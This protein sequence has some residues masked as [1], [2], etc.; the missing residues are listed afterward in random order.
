L[1]C[2]SNAYSLQQQ[3]HF[4]GSSSIQLELQ[5]KALQQ[6][7]KQVAHCCKLT[8]AVTLQFFE[9]SQTVDIAASL[10]LLLLSLRHGRYDRCSAN[11]RTRS[12]CNRH[13]HPTAFICTARP[14]F[15]LL[16]LLLTTQGA[17]LLGAAASSSCEG[18]CLQ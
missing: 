18:T 2:T 12:C 1:Q 10:Q 15:L 8:A 7:L 13:R 3:Q 6:Q 5:A 4:S 16:L 9:R 11:P 14:L 17:A